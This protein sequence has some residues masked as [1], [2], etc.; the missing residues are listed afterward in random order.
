VVRGLLLDQPG[1]DPVPF[2]F[3]AASVSALLLAGRFVAGAAAALLVVAGTASAEEVEVHPLLG[4][5]Y[6][7][8]R[9]VPLLVVA[10]AGTRSVAASASR[11]ALVTGTVRA[12]GAFLPIP[13]PERLDRV[14]VRID[15]ADEPIEVPVGVRPKP[16]GERWYVV[17]GPVSPDL[18]AAAREKG[19]ALSRA[20]PEAESMDPDLLSA[21]G[22]VDLSERLTGARVARIRARGVPVVHRV[23]DLPEAAEQEHLVRRIWEEPGRVLEAGDLHGYFP[24]AARFEPARSRAALLLLAGFAAL[25]VMA[26]RF[27]GRRGWSAARSLILLVPP[28][29]AATIAAVL[30]LPPPA[31]VRW[32]S[33]VLREGVRVVTLDRVL[34]L[35]DT[36]AEREF[37]GLPLPLGRAEDVEIR[38]DDGARIRVPLRAREARIFVREG[39]GAPGPGGT[40]A[41]FD[42]LVF[43]AGLALPGEA[44]RP[45]VEFL[46]EELDG[47]RGRAL[48]KLLKLGAERRG[49]YGVRFLGPGVAEIEVVRVE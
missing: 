19:I 31:P 13:G 38:V 17:F 28:A 33:I 24:P 15:G 22:V 39:G 47:V 44:P 5:L 29:T 8:G 36:V 20:R 14:G 16:P 25:A 32:D 18:A 9:A 21:D 40:D 35:R 42:L 12:E 7:P 48:P 6:A 30:A 41:P 43:P 2:L 34:A 37:P 27:A 49:T 4:D 1:A 45:V 23:E 26:I 10:P 11:G 3:F 46:R